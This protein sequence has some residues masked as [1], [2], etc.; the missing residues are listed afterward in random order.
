MYKYYFTL[1][2]FLKQLSC[3][4]LQTVHSW[5]LTINEE[6]D[7]LVILRDNRGGKQ[8]DSFYDMFP[9]LETE[10]KMFSIANSSKKSSLFTT[11]TLAMFINERYTELTGEAFESGEFIRSLSSCRI[12]LIRWGAKFSKN[13]KRPYFSGHERDDVVA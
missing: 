4:C 13:K 11:Q 5:S 7:P 10:A 3:C 6:N 12:D 9:D 1:V 8:R 2:N